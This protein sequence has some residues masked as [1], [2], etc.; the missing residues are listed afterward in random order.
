MALALATV[1]SLALRAP[2]VRM[3]VDI[4]KPAMSAESIGNYGFD[5]LNLGTGARAIHRWS[6]LCSLACLRT[7]A[8][9]LGIGLLSHPCHSPYATHRRDVHA[10]S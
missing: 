7:H 10:V 8:H 2:A 5:P 9:T 4:P 1:S 6:S 3:A